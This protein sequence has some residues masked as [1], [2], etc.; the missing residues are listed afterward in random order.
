MLDLLDFPVAGVTF[1]NEDG[2]SR[3]AILRR[4]EKGQIK[5]FDTDFELYNYEGSPA[6]HVLCDGMCVGNVPK[7]YI[8]SVEQIWDEIVIASLEVESFEDDYGKTIYRADVH[9][10][11]GERDQ[12]SKAEQKKEESTADSVSNAGQKNGLAQ[13][14]D[15][16]PCRGLIMLA[17]VIS[18]LAFFSGMYGAAIAGT[19]AQPVDWYGWYG[20]RIRIA[21]FAA[22]IGSSM[23]I[24]GLLVRSRP[25][26]L[27]CCIAFCFSAFATLISF[28]IMLLPLIFVIVGYANMRHWPTEQ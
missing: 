23:G 3:Q 18:T 25:A 5:D 28:L 14:E 19:F 17:L 2:S 1:K 20:L 6:I 15:I 16:Y 26:I 27:I 8:S 22:A 21:F 11:Y 4:I 7:K 12:K 13:A 24:A 9:V 10:A